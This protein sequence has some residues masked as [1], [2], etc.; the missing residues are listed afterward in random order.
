MS[1]QVLHFIS[2]GQKP[3]TNPETISTAE[4]GS[5]IIKLL[6]ASTLKNKKDKHERFHNLSTELSIPS[7]KCLEQDES[8]ILAY[9]TVSAYNEEPMASKHEVHLFQECLIHI[10]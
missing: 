8:W 1:P 2:M 5:S 7:L 6:I 10:K 3:V 4:G 9:S